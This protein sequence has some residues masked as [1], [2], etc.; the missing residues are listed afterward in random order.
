MNKPIKSGEPEREK[1][2][3]R[4]H[5]TVVH[6]QIESKKETSKKDK[7]YLMPPEPERYIK[8]KK[9]DPL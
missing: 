2:P 4:Q 7:G 9:N 3:S 8:P 5:L 1:I 6:R